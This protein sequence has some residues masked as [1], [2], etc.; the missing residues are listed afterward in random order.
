MKIDEP[1]IEPDKLEKTA[2]YGVNY[3][4]EVVGEVNPHKG[5]T[6]FQYNTVTEELT[7]AEFEKTDLVINNLDASGKDM[8]HFKKTDKILVKENCIYT[9]ALN[10]KNAI[11]KFA[12]MLS[13][14]L[15]NE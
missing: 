1:K 12:K 8:K 5:H 9:V 15:N 4:E 10:E 7:I 2:Q 6:C 11:K 3:V 13:K 14:M